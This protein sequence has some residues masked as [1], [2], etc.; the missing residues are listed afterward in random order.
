MI[1]TVTALNQLENK[2]TSNGSGIEIITPST[3]TYNKINTAV[4]NGLL[5]VL[6]VEDNGNGMTY[7]NR[8]NYYEFDGTEYI[9]AFRGNIYSATNANSVMIL[10]AQP[11]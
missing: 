8:L 4:N 7:L 11:V 3:L 10:D 2:F 1:I 6:K 5:P 9:A